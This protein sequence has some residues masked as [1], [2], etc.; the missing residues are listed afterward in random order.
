MRNILILVPLVLLLTV[1]A[2]KTQ[3]VTF[4]RDDI[5]YILELPSPLWRP[6]PRLDVH[7]HVEFINRDDYS[8]GYLRLRKRLVTAG[9]GP[10]DLFRYDEKWELQALPGYVVCS[11]GNGARIEGQLSGTAYAYEYVNNGRAMDGRIYYLQANNRIFYVLHFT[12]ASDKRQ[13][14]RE[15]MDFIARSFRIK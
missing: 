6:V 1:S 7:S 2:A 4:T 8:N 5:D 13:S 12:V 3:T 14:L 10:D 15:Q 9:A 11:N